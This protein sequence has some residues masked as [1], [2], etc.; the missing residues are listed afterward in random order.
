MSERW[1]ARL[2]ERGTI[3]LKGKSEPIALYALKREGARAFAR[4]TPRRR[5]PHKSSV[6][7][8]TFVLTY[9]PRG[10]PAAARGIGRGFVARTGLEEGVR[11]SVPCGRCSR[12]HPSRPLRSR[13]RRQVR[14]RRPSPRR[15]THGTKRRNP[16]RP[17]SP[18]RPPSLEPEAQ[19]EPASEERERVRIRSV[20]PPPA[21]RG[22]QPA[23]PV[24]PERRPS[25]DR[26][27]ASGSTRLRPVSDAI[28]AL[29]PQAPSV[30][31]PRVRRPPPLPRR[32]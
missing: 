5:Q 25:I 1:R 23:E 24:E 7:P 32:S 17:S 31:R 20:S 2:E 27:R 6:A 30:R 11:R 12:W 26:R 16:R 28:G 13:P 21:A 14:R 10:R 22:E 15:R 19:A 8:S 4:P 29:L 3:P 9:A 18:P